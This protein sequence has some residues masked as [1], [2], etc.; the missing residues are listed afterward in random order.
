ML[1]RRDKKIGCIQRRRNHEKNKEEKEEKSKKK[2]KKKKGWVSWS[3]EILKDFKW[4][5][6]KRLWKNYNGFRIELVHRLE[7]LAWAF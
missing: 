5:L 3:S 7:L 6:T 2:K 4:F 1:V